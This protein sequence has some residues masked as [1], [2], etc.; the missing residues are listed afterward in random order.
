MDTPRPQ[1]SRLGAGQKA[2][3]SGNGV[4]QPVLGAVFGELDSPVD[5]LLVAVADEVARAL[6]VFEG[7]LGGR[8]RGDHLS[9]LLDGARG[10]LNGGRL[11]G[12]LLQ[13]AQPLLQRRGVRGYENPLL[14]DVLHF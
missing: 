1:R 3:G 5:L 2:G 8:A 14:N 10:R 4:A 12:L 7:S 9:C 6:K 11:R 13:L